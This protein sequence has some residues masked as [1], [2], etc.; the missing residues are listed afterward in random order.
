MPGELIVVVKKD[1]QGVG[2]K[3][4]KLHSKPGFSAKP[5][6]KRERFFHLV[7]LTP[8]EAARIQDEL[9]NDPDIEIVQPNYI[10]ET[11]A[12]PNDLY[13]GRHWSLKNTGQT[14]TGVNPTQ[15]RIVGKNNPGTP[16]KDIAIESVWDHITDCSNVPVAVIDT[17]AKLEH[18]DL[19]GNLWS[20]GAEKGLDT[21]DDDF[22]PD[23]IVNG[24][25]THV[26]STIAA[27]SDNGIG[28]SG[29]CWKASIIP[30]RAMGNEGSG[31]I[32]HIIRAI[33]YAAKEKKAKIINM[34]LG[35]AGPE[36]A[37]FRAAI[38]DAPNSLF[39]V[40]AGNNASDNTTIPIWPCNFSL[41]LD[42][43][44][45]IGAVDQ[46]FE[47]A[48]YSNYSP[49]AVQ[50]SAPGTNIVGGS[51][52]TGGL[53]IQDFV[54]WNLDAEWERDTS[55]WELFIPTDYDGTTKTYGNNL[56]SAAYIS[57]DYSIY[58]Y[59]S[60]GLNI[61]YDLGNNGDEL[62]FAVDRQNGNIFTIPTGAFRSITKMSGSGISANLPAIDI[63][64][65]CAGQAA[66][67]L[68]IR[69][70]SGAGPTGFGAK[71]TKMYITKKTYATNSYQII[72][73][74]SMATPHVTG[75]AALLWAYNPDF[76]VADVKAAIINGGKTVAGLASKNST[77]KVLNAMGSFTHIAKPATPMPQ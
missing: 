4:S 53:F 41:T 18:E 76:G 25:G 73:G 48:S 30:I 46:E 64:S 7:G 2:A 45:C 42:N 11:Q 34:S 51:A 21:I 37:A 26:T 71:L 17:G 14:V 13:Y 39:I 59:V 60:W 66:C 16:G 56:T 33:E 43:V 19:I 47:H 57:G 35:G 22:E 27:R 29:I 23:D 38:A 5:L 62:E 65:T 20:D 67:T 44:I 10:Y 52:T 54:D 24:H 15:D 49:T 3:L 77:S 28:T 74:T 58:D 69:L 72:N 55:E 32:S 12:Q 9:S 8:D 70:T 61:K 36:D 6:S 75:V 1:R 50:I 31:P 40:A 63:T 68:G